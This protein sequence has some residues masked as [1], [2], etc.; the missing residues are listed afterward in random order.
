MSNS[1]DSYLIDPTPREDYLNWLETYKKDYNTV[2]QAECAKVFKNNSLVH[3]WYTKLVPS[4][5]SE[6][7]F[8]SRYF[9]RVHILDKE[10]QVRRALV[11]K[12][13]S[14]SNSDQKQVAADLSWGEDGD[15]DLVSSST[16]T[17]TQSQSG[18]DIEQT[19]ST[20]SNENGVD[21]SSTS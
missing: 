9:Y 1:A 6:T 4:R 12:L 19:S 2:W 15:E 13:S 21:V 5:V 3:A 11:S 8:Y 10:E 14:N 16:S 20:P 7:D 17:E 18:S